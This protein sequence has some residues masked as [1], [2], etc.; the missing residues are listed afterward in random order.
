MFCNHVKFQK[1]CAWDTESQFIKMKINFAFFLNFTSNTRWILTKQVVQ[2]CITDISL[3]LRIM[4]HLSER[5]SCLDYVA[6]SNKVNV[7]DQ[8]KSTFDFLSKVQFTST[9]TQL[10]N[11]KKFEVASVKH[12]R[13]LTKPRRNTAKRDKTNTRSRSDNYIYVILVEKLFT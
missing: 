3:P 2:R 12:L 9:K 6:G 11:L 7:S 13:S 8:K 4:Y 5:H 10:K 1:V